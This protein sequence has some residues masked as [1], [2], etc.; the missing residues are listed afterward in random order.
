VGTLERDVA[1]LGGDVAVAQLERD[2]ARL[3]GDVAV[4]RLGCDVARLGDDVAMA[5]PER[6]VAR[7]GGDVAVAQLERDVA[8]ARLGGGVAVAQLERDVA[9]LGGDVSVVWVGGP[10]CFSTRC[11][12]TL[13]YPSQWA[14][15]PWCFSTPRVCAWVLGLFWRAIFVRP[16][17]LFSAIAGEVADIV[18]FLCLC[19][20][21]VGDL[22]AGDLER[23]EGQ[24]SPLLVMG[25][26][27]DAAWL[28][29]QLT[30]LLVMGLAED[31]A[32]LEGQLT[33]LLVMGQGEDATWLE[34]QLTP[35]LMTDNWTMA[36]ALLLR[37]GDVEPHPGPLRIVV[38]NVT[39]LR[40]RAAEVFALEADIVALQETRLGAVAQKVMATSAKFEGWEAYWGAPRKVQP[41]AS[42]TSPSAGKIWNVHPGGVGVLIRR[43]WAAR[44]V[45]I[46]KGDTV[47]EYLRDS[48]RWLHVYVTLGDGRTGM[49]LQVIYGHAS[50]KEAN[51]RLM[52]ALWEYTTRLGNTPS[53]V[54]GDFNV[55]LNEPLGLPPSMADTLCLGTYVDL[56]ALHSTTHGVPTQSSCMTANSIRSTRIDGMFADQCTATGLQKVEALDTSFPTHTAVRYVLALAQAKQEVRKS[57]RLLDLEFTRNLDEKEQEAIAGEACRPQLAEFRRMVTEK[58]VEGAMKLWSLMAETT[59]VKLADPG[60]PLRGTTGRCS[61]TMH[62]MTTMQP[63]HH[64]KCGKPMTQVLT[65]VSKASAGLRPL[66]SHLRRGTPGVPPMG[67]RT[68]MAG[69]AET[70]TAGDGAR[71][72]DQLATATSLGRPPQPRRSD[73]HAQA[74][75]GL[76]TT[77]PGPGRPRPP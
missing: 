64:T 26:A 44:T 41:P 66:L 1:R 9:R 75:G 43:P 68:S 2:V 5:K 8:V 49:N 69:L 77:T 38:A 14:P 28:E 39:S 10:L 58:D 15:R 74:P 7:L 50:D 52:N 18:R 67:S 51:V 73:G 48:T 53:V 4:A 60:Q 65:A 20:C 40:R 33:P 56:D 34:G 32:W 24:Q 63:R 76:L 62:I 47:G 42:K 25:L 35:P 16:L 30:P 55:S 21:S 36:L 13:C 12:L 22:V 71:P 19:A 61:T 37:C 54:T 6:D 23:L 3:G 11:F 46:A 27:E 17:C 29:G 31:A 45:A 57:R 59:W 72:C 70:P